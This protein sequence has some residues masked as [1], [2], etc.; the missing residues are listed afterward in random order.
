MHVIRAQRMPPDGSVDTAG[1]FAFSPT[2][3]DLATAFSAGTDEHWHD[4]SH[5]IP[6]ERGR[7]VV[8]RIRR[9]VDA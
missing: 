2:W 4:C 8:E 1:A 3:P 6:M 7:E 9:M 5:F